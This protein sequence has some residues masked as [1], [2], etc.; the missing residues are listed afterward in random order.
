MSAQAATPDVI[1]VDVRPHRDFW[2]RV[3]A[4]AAPLPWLLLAV[5]NAVTPED[6]GGSYGNQYDAFVDHPTS[7]GVA[8]AFSILCAATL[9]PA[10]VAMLVAIRRTAPRGAIL[11]GGLWALGACCGAAAVSMQVITYVAAR[12]DLDRQTVIALNEAIESSPVYLVIIPFAL[13]IMLG[14]VLLGILLWRIR[15]APRWMAVALVAAVP[16]EWVLG[17]AI[18]NAGPALAYVL[19]ATGFAS[20]SVA[21]IRQGR[22]AHVVPR[23]G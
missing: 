10:A 15:I 8:V 12:E 1:R 13:S 11:V 23:V 4:I 20:A 6:L 17:A 21:L 9:V 3:L 2:R 22:D 16:V 19:T 7:S 14:R 5:S 18:G